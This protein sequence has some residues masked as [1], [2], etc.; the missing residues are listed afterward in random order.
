[1]IISLIC[2]SS[3]ESETDSE[4]IEV[5]IMTPFKDKLRLSISIKNP[6]LQKKHLQVV[7]TNPI[8]NYIMNADK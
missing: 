3:K 7:N 5:D 2:F 4:G 1:M 8:D 6:K